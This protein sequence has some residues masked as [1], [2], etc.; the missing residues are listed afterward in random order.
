MPRSD[1]KAIVL[2]D[3]VCN[4]C[5]GTVQFI[6]KRDRRGYFQFA[7]LQ[8]PVGKTLLADRADL[9]NLDSIVLIE[10]GQIFTESTAVLRIVRKLDGGLWR[11]SS[12]LL[13]VPKALRDPCY[14]F[15]ARHRYRFF[16]R[17]ASCMIPT[18]EM[19][20]RFLPLDMPK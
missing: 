13:A 18:A 11:C 5:N 9:Q 10:D 12:V 16:G 6:I 19:K 3:G 14:R 17:K 8:S 20:S 1:A 2:F 4:L 7:P 15:V